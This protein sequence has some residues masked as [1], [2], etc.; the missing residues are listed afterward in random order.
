MLRFCA[1]DVEVCLFWV[2]SAIPVASDMADLQE[3]RFCIKF[4]DLAK[5]ASQTYKNTLRI[6][7]W[8]SPF[9]SSQTF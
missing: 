8:R 4:F 6:L 1:I 7:S 2:H 9:K 3:Q 5:A